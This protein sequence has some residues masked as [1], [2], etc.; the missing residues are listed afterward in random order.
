[1]IK[2]TIYILLLLSFCKSNAQNIDSVFQKANDAY[3]HAFYEE[4]LHNYHKIDS[5]EMQS[6][7]LYYNLGNTYYKLNQIA[8]SIYYYEKALLLDPKHED[9]KQ[10][11]AFAQR[12]TI[13]AFETLPKSF[14]QKINEIVI[15]PVSYNTWAWIT[16]V[17]AFLIGVFFLW[18]HFSGN[19][20]AKRLFFTISLISIG[21]FLLSLSFVIKAKHYSNHNQPA[22][23]FST[24]VSV[25]SEPNTSAS[26]TFE[27]HE[28]TKVLVLDKI[29]NWYKIKLADG[30][31]GWLKEETIKKLK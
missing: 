28:G 26:K 20:N 29:D 16:V 13:D 12:M 23:V 10:N 2:N 30:K 9:A 25:K 1:M 17:F 18:Y 8:P 24:K 11:L 15:Y 5:L 31:V 14:F 3:R 22:I 27:L 21:L 4:A 19:A 6:A 7:D